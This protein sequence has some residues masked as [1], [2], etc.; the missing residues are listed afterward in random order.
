MLD[1]SPVVAGMICQIRSGTFGKAL[2]EH[3]T[4]QRFQALRPNFTCA[5]H[6]RCHH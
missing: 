2:R 1:I 3:P 4:L 5:A 6:D